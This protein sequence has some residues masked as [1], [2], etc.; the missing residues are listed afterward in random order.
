L[1]VSEVPPDHTTFIQDAYICDLKSL[2]VG[3][4]MAPGLQGGTESSV[5]NTFQINLLSDVVVIEAR[6]ILDKLIEL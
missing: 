5:E 4:G 3:A 1:S 2:R 6:A